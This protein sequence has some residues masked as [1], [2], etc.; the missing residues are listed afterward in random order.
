MQQN[1]MLKT[2]LKVSEGDMRKK[3]QIIAQLTNEIKIGAQ[4]QSMGFYQPNFNG[5]PNTNSFVQTPPE[6]MAIGTYSGSR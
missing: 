2:N 3:D 1:T 6:L 5:M 4:Q